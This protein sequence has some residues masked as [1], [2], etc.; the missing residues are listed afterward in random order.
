MIYGS[1]PWLQRS[2]DARAAANF[3]LGGTGSGML[4]ILAFSDAAGTPLRAA[5][6]LALALVAAGL[7]AVWLEIGR[8][9]RAIH[10]LFNPFTSWMSRESFAAALL[11][12]LGAAAAAFPQAGLVLAAALAALAFV[13]CQG[14]ILQNARGIPA[15][16]E[17]AVLPLIVATALAEGAGALVVVGTIAGASVGAPL[18]WCAFAAIARA[19]AWSVYR[20]RLAS[21]ARPCLDVLDRAGNVLIALGTLVPLALLVVGMLLTD[22]LAISGVLAGI[23][24]VAAGWTFKIMLVTRAALNQGF[25]L[26]ELPARGRTMHSRR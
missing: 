26:P 11:F 21:A 7:G 1:S 20:R 3:A 18:A 16:R 24:T 10:V 23:A 22:V 4:V 14:R 25:A 2:W 12:A 17:P 5:L 9:E 15:W 13:Y 8:P 19:L 6:M